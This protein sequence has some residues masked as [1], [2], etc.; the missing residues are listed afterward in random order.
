MTLGL[1]KGPS[2]EQ[3]IYQIS[4]DKADTINVINSIPFLLDAVSA[5]CVVCNVLYAVGIGFNYKELW[6]WSAS[7]DEWT[8]CADLPSGRRRHCVT[9]VGDKIY[10]LGGW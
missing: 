4:L 3:K 10:V 2:T 5:A 9:S 6:K 7:R 8:R 1:Y